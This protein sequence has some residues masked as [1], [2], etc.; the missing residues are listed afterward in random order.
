MYFEKAGETTS[1]EGGVV[2]EIALIILLVMIV[3]EVKSRRRLTLGIGGERGM[4]HK[5]RPM[6]TRLRADTKGIA[7]RHPLIP[8]GTFSYASTL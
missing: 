7:D 3:W 8:P 2:H 4:I 5:G 6:M 1:K